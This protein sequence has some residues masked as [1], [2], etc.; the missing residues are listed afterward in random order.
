MEFTIKAVD[1]KKMISELEPPTLP[2]LE[3]DSDFHVIT[4]LAMPSVLKRTEVSSIPTITPMTSLF[5]SKYA[6][7]KERSRF[8]R[9]IRLGLL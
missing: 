2:K 5:K 7:E 3:N 1:V 4:P 8:E 6:E 9:S